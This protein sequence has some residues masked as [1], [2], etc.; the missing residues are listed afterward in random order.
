MM[1]LIFFIGFFYRNTAML[2]YEYR[3]KR[4]I[5]GSFYIEPEWLK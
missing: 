2:P 3:V 1:M 5:S 4:C